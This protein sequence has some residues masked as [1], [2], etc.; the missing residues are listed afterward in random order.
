MKLVLGVLVCFTFALQS[1]TKDDDDS[2]YISRDELS[3]SNGSCKVSLTGQS[4]NGYMLNEIIDLPYSQK[5]SNYY[6]QNDSIAS[7]SIYQYDNIVMPNSFLQLSIRYNSLTA[8]ATVNTC[9]LT[10]FKEIDDKNVINVIA[11]FQSYSYLQTPS[12]LTI[13]N[14]VF[15][16]ILGTISGTLK[17]SKTYSEPYYGAIKPAVEPYIM[18]MKADFSLNVKLAVNSKLAY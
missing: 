5:R 9:Y 1:C 14:F 4:E 8:K 13:S 2:M 3:V 6:T 10:Y 15:D 18:V 11:T 7:F 12:Q 16:K 17:G